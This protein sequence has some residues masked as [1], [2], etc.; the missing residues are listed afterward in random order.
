MTR[1]QS[2]EKTYIIPKGNVGNC[3][4]IYEIKELKSLVPVDK[5]FALAE[6]W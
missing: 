6:D 3:Q 1:L 5:K 4:T 2:K